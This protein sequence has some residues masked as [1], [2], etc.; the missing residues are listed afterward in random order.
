[1]PPSSS[2]QTE[3]GTFRVLHVDDK[4]DLLEMVSIFLEREDD[5]FEIVQATSA[6]NG[7][8]QLSEQAFDCVISDYDMPSCNGIEFLQEVREDS[9]DLP[10]ILFTG[11][12]IEEIASDAIS[13]GVTDLLQ[14]QG[15]TDCYT[16]LANSVSNAIEHYPDTPD[17]PTP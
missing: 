7:L 16:V 9:P 5:R 14:K 3:E 11:K 15:A 10:F 2:Q 12:G 1:M 4:P 6:S 8:D 17:N 13:A